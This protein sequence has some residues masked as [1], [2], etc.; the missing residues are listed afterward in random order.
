MK[1]LSI[2]ISIIL[3]ILFS[4]SFFGCEEQEKGYYYGYESALTEEEHVKNLNKFANI[5]YY[6]LVEYGILDDYNVKIIYNFNGEP[7][8]FLLELIGL[9]DLPNR[10]GE[11]YESVYQQIYDVSLYD[12]ISSELC[13]DE[14]R[15]TSKAAQISAQ[16]FIDAGVRKVNVQFL[17]VIYKDKY[18]Y[19]DSRYDASLYVNRSYD[20]ILDEDYDG[21][22]LKMKAVQMHFFK[23]EVEKQ[24]SYLMYYHGY[25]GYF[26]R[27]NLF[28][29]TYFVEK[30]STE[31]NLLTNSAY[32]D[33]KIYCGVYQD[34]RLVFGYEDN[35]EIYSLTDM[36]MSVE[37]NNENSFSIS[38]NQVIDKEDYQKLVLR[39]YKAPYSDYS[40]F[41]TRM[42]ANM[43]RRYFHIHGSES[44]PIYKL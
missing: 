28:K 16:E 33:K 25:I 5:T 30:E 4:F 35:G 29:N 24:Q 20:E 23:D 37:V 31:P 42:F 22:D 6:P 27:F 3:S 41:S 9:L 17:G 14:D 38:H 21:E 18:L 10:E 12:Y 13:D 11:G 2:L 19:Y 32:K 7:Q 43:G 26:T 39:F 44:I 8:F 40:A 1:K 36:Q 34:K 15:E